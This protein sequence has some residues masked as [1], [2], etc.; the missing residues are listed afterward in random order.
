MLG[1]FAISGATR[2]E[3]AAFD[4]LDEIKAALGDQPNDRAG[5]RLR[6]I[7]ALDGLLVATGPI[8]ARIVPFAGKRARPVRAILFDKSASTNWSLAW[9]QDRT[10]CVRE[11]RD[12]TGFGP[13]TVKAGMLHVAPP[14]DLLE[15][16]VTIRV[17]LDDAAKDNAP[18]LIAPGS[19]R[20][21]LVREDAVDAAVAACG[22]YM[23]LAEAGDIWVYATPILHASAAA[24]T[25]RRRRVLQ[26]DY[27]EFELP[28]GLEWSG[29]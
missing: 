20:L 14:F 3:A 16:M 9:H 7:A 28:G 1:P 15:R 13:W 21:G 2:L 24:Q 26:V 18:L 11:R 27:A 22:T 23:C 29:I 4:Q 8:G 19:H 5:V 25:P 10:I 17:H 12:V 6:G